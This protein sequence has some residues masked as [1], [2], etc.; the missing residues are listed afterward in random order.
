MLKEKLRED[1][2]TAMKAKDQPK[3][4][5]LRM[6]LS[7]ISYGETLATP[8][9]ELK[10]VQGYRKK[11]AEALELTSTPELKYELEIVE[12]YLPKQAT[13]EEIVLT[14]DRIV[15]TYTDTIDPKAFGLLM[16]A[17]KIELPNADGKLLS[18]LLKARMGI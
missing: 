4:S 17:A 6:M 1:M 16:K 18:E 2:K 10:S 13:K 3:L 8:Q 14:V 12:T 11:V 5:A 7:A 9:D 15:S